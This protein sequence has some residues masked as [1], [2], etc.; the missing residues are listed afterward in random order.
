MIEPTV[1]VLR[2]REGVAV[3]MLHGEHDVACREH[4]ATILDDLVGENALVVV[5]VS[6]ADFIDSSFVHA[7]VQTAETARGKGT[8]LRLQT[9]ATP[10]VQRALAVSGALG[11]VEVLHTRDEALR[12]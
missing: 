11:A 8:T 3:A 10:I 9:G 4:D 5:D 1:Q 6:Q 7:L 2:P 12:A